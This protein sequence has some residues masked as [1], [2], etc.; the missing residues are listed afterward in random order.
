MNRL[1]AGAGE[2]KRRRL[3]ELFVLSS[4]YEWL[5]WEMCWRGE[6]WPV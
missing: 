6:E 1:A 5:F 3:V 2:G 4:R